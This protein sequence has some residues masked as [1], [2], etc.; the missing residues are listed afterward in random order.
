MSDKY[1]QEAIKHLGK[2]EKFY[3]SI[4]RF[5]SEF[6]YLEFVLRQRIAEAVALN[7]EFLDQIISHDFAM[8]CTIAQNVMSRGAGRRTRDQS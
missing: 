2:G 3:S 5:I 6:S 8:L 4:G 1:H 7:F